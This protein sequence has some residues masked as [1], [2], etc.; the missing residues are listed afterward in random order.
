MKKIFITGI[1]GF[2]GSNLAESLLKDGHE[3]IGVDDLSS[4]KQENIER[5]DGM[6]TKKFSFHKMDIRENEI[7]KLM[8]G[9]DLIIHLAAH[10]IPRYGGT[11]NSLRVNIFG[12][13]N[14]FRCAKGIPVILASTSDVYGKLDKI[15]FKEDDNLVLGSSE[16]RRWSYA[17]SKMID[18]HFAFAFKE[19]FNQDFNI[20]RFFNIYGEYCSLNWT[21]GA[22]PQII[23][24]ALRNEEIEVH[25][26]GKQTRCY[27][28]VSDIIN[29]LRKLIDSDVKNEILNIGSVNLISVNKLVSLIYDLIGVKKSD[30]KIKYIPYKKFFGKYEDVRERKPDISKIKKLL[31]W[32]PSINL[33]EGLRRTIEW[34]KSLISE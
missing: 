26:D 19:R 3:V 23:G 6:K 12:T 34:Q 18:E 9:C 14:I 21:G 16:C 27:V 4:G 1:A 24:R 13:Y 29:G 11:Y 20:I 22:V 15:P 28:H 25:G 8:E 32:E 31:N 33:K 17:A 5:L 2:I 10:K 30:R 7:E